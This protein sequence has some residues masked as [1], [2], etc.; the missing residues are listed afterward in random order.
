[1]NIFNFYT[2]F[3]MNASWFSIFFSKIFWRRW[4]SF[5][6]TSF[7]ECFFFSNIDVCI[8]RSMI[9]LMFISSLCKHLNFTSLSFCNKSTLIIII[10]ESVLLLST[11]Y[12]ICHYLFIYF[13]FYFFICNAFFKS[14]FC[15]CCDCFLY[16][17]N[18]YMNIDYKFII[19]YIVLKLLS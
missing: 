12:A 7:H 13:D 15:T 16:Q 11:T 10:S 2:F 14:L 18:H 6:I 3:V 17:L 5:R 1:M 19:K 9:S 8:N 4:I